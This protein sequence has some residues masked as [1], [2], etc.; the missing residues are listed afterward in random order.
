MNSA[1]NFEVLPPPADDG[2][3]LDFRASSWTYV[4]PVPVRAFK[5]HDIVSIRVDEL[6]RMRAEGLAESRKNGGFDSRLR[7]WL[8]LDGLS[9]K[10][11]KFSD[12]DLRVRSSLNSLYRADAASESRESLA[13]NIAAEI[14]D[15]RPN[16]TLVLE[17]HKMIWINDNAW[18]T[19]L[20]GICRAQDVGPDNVVLSRDVLDLQ[21][22]KQERGRVR[23]G[24][25][26]GWFTQWFETLQ[27]F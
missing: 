17:A 22:S 18:D 14:V 9:L 2:R 27:P 8:R 24:Y 1:P 3:P 19:S 5:P 4:P 12:G 10:P 16:G 6:T 13:L 11:A 21:I 26:R 25:R 7:D 20:H 23:D 15:I